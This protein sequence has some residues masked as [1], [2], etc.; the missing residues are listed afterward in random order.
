MA[1]GKVC[2]TAT[3]YLSYEMVF[4]KVCHLPSN[5]VRSVEP[6]Y[7]LEVYV[8]EFK[9]RTQEANKDARKYLLKYKN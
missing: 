9:Y 1:Y 6:I 3:V 7:N 4:R 5:L 2:N 8:K